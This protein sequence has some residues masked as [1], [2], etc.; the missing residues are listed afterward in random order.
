MYKQSFFLMSCRLEEEVKELKIQLQQSPQKEEIVRWVWLLRILTKDDSLY[1][2]KNNRLQ[3]QI[4]GKTKD[5]EKLGNERDDI[6]EALNKL[7]EQYNECAKPEMVQRSVQESHVTQQ[8]WVN[9]FFNCIL[10]CTCKSSFRYKEDIARLEKDVEERKTALTRC[11]LWDSFHIILYVFYSDIV[12]SFVHVFLQWTNH[13]WSVYY[14]HMYMIVSSSTIFFTLFSSLTQSW[15]PGP[16]A[17]EWPPV[18][19][20]GRE[21]DWV[22]GTGQGLE[23]WQQETVWRTQEVRGLHKV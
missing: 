4:E 20:Q 10:Y 5:L 18:R 13:C 6:R 19:S 2:W 23:S 8:L 21:G 3:A 22:G 12:H 16:T 15:R 11:S 1:L 14:T 9:I 17:T 7:Q